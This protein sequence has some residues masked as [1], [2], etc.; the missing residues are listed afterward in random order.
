MIFSLGALTVT[1]D[2]CFYSFDISAAVQSS[3]SAG[4]RLARVMRLLRVIRV[5]RVF[6]SCQKQRNPESKMQKNQQSAI[7]KRIN[8]N[9]VKSMILVRPPAESQISC[10]VPAPMPRVAPDAVAPDAAA[11]DAAATS[12]GHLPR[13][14]PL[15]LTLRS[16]A[17]VLDSRTP[18]QIV[19][20]LS[21][22]FP[23]LTYEEV[24]VSRAAAFSMLAL[25][26]AGALPAGSP[27][28]QGLGASTFSNMLDDYRFQGESYDSE[29]GGYDNLKYM[30]LLK[31]VVN[32][33]SVVYGVEGERITGP[34]A[35]TC[36][37]DKSY[38]FKGC[39]AHIARTRCSFLV[40]IPA[41]TTPGAK[42]QAFWDKTKLDQREAQFSITL[43]CLLIIIILIMCAAPRPSPPRPRPSP[44]RA[45][46]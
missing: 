7:G 22:I 19:I 27:M 23:F 6:A 29:F 46:Q 44:S 32:D 42:Y 21:I 36:L 5:I 33:E 24:D 3:W 1:P 43:T 20:A 15:S 8:E 25:G 18:R 9:L 30:T 40:M 45:S 35:D 31:T 34:D 14:L 13:A 16:Y 12:V 28:A 41:G 10:P 37:N 38:S 11:P 26:S 4:T 17:S 39:P 2:E